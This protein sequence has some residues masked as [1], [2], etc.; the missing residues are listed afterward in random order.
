MKAI[1]EQKHY[2]LLQIGLNLVSLDWKRIKTLMQ[3]PYLVVDCRMLGNIK[4]LVINMLAF[5]EV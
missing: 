3:T 4:Y 2:Y 1:E 5:V